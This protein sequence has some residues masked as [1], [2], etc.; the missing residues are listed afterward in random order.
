MPLK[1]VTVSLALAA[2]LLGSGCATSSRQS[3]GVVSD[4]TAAV[5]R[6]T[7]Y[8]SPTVE[9]DRT[10]GATPL[11]AYGA[12]EDDGF[13]L[14]AIPVKKIDPQFLRQ[15]VVYDSGGYEEGTVV[16]DTPHR[17]LYV[18]ERGGTAMRY[19]IGVGKDGF[20][21]AGE[22]RI[23]DKQHWPRWF[24]PM[25]MIERRK[26]LSKFKDGKGMD[27]GPMNPL[28]SRALYLH[29]NGRDTLYR[30][31]GNPEW[32][33]IGKAASSGCIRL[34]NQDIIDLYE[35]V[36]LG[37]RVVVLQGAERMVEPKAPATAKSRKVEKVASV[38]SRVA[39]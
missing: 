36:P 35:R 28:G 21:W 17:F 1:T 39:G 5:A 38:R 14:P 37:A 24:P 10:F 15:R 16:V 12:T 7:A 27:P 8:V 18:V 20:S 19:G 25:E 22:A 31:H 13:H 6:I 11:E 3:A 30:L 34:I 9:D 29:Q 26:D 32:Q 4:T 2:T 33:S 23:G